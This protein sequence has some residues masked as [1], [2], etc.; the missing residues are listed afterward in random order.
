MDLGEVGRHR[1][2]AG[3]KKL[4]SRVWL[5]CHGY[6]TRVFF[7]LKVLNVINSVRELGGAIREM[8]SAFGLLEGTG[9]TR[10][11]LQP[12]EHRAHPRAGWRG[13][14]GREP[15]GPLWPGNVSSSPNCSGLPREHRF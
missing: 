8:C 1:Q 7:A 13:G 10:L 12:H 14:A 9:T 3:N 11:F 2:Q 4:S 15:P 5:Y 6:C